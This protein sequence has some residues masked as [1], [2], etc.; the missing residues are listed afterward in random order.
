MVILG[1]CGGH[2]A[3]WCV[4]KDGKL[5]GAFEKERFTRIRHDGGAIMD[6]VDRSLIKLGISFDEVDMIATSE[7]NFRGTD[8]GINYLSKQLYNEPDEWVELSVEFHGRK[9]PCFSIPHH[10]CHAAYGYYTSGKSEGTVL[11]W[12]GGGDFYTV[13]AYTSTS[14]SQWRGKKLQHF[15]RID[16]SDLGSLWHIYSQTLFH[17]PY[18]AGKLMGLAAL[19]NASLI[20]DVTNYCLRPVRGTLNPALSIKNCWADEDSPYYGA[21]NTWKHRQAPD[22]AFA[23]QSATLSAGL[24]LVKAAYEK[25]PSKYLC[26]SGGV[27]LNGYLNTAI[28]MLGLFDYVH[29]PPSV[30]DGGLSIGATLFCMNNILNLGNDAI[31]EEE[32]V[33]SGFEYDDATCLEAL[34]KSR[35]QYSEHEEMESLEI[36]ATAISSGS[37]VAW[38]SGKSE[39]GPRALGHRS[40]LASPTYP[41]MKERLNNTIKFREYFRPVAPVVLEED[42]NIC[43]ND[44]N[45]SPYMMHIVKTTKQFQED[46]PSGIHL[47]GTARV[48]S[49]STSNPMGKILRIMK[50]DNSGYAL[51]N[52]SFN[53]KEPIVETPFDAVATFSKVPIDTLVLNHKYVVTR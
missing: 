29:I 33:F 4:F 46:N 27:A 31:S 22:L 26:L 23:I 16:N 18:A 38:Y 53:C 24:N 9:V 10:L 44:V 43:T 25:Y 12:D 21:I 35:L 36:A 37:I 3:N 34:E 13:N 39:H 50:A 17:D 41:Q 2:D 30:H 42:M 47:D 19:G 51:L 6:L 11:T 40:L 15:E 14:V 5:M 49:V 45:R 7:A 52:T 48:Q 8:P 32:L 28:S 20:E 1:L